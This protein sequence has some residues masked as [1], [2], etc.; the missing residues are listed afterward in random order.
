MPNNMLWAPRFTSF[1]YV[2]R[3][4]G[5]KEYMFKIIESKE[6]WSI[7]MIPNLYENLKL[8]VVVKM[9]IENE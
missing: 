5:N 8:G 6:F 9:V 7:V 3:T 2:M 4:R 1:E